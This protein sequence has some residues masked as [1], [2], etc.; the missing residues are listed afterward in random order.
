MVFF[1]YGQDLCPLKCCDAVEVTSFLT[2]ADW[3]VSPVPSKSKTSR[4]RL[5]ATATASIPATW[6]P[7]GE[8]NQ[9]CE[10]CLSSPANF[11]H[12]TTSKP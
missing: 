5:E 1:L 10:Q 7:T 12:W 2:W 3:L 11:C 4:V 9:G 8:A 6:S